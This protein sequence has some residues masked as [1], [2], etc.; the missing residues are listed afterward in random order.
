M[1][2]AKRSLSVDLCLIP[3]RPLDYMLGNYGC[4]LILNQ[5]YLSIKPI[6]PF[7]LGGHDQYR[8]SNF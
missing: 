2:L 8:T 3:D 5:N 6:N 1:V 4:I 7:N